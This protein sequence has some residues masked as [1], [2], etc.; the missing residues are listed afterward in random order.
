MRWLAF[1]GYKAQDLHLGSQPRTTCH[2]SLALS[3]SPSGSTTTSGLAS[4]MIRTPL[5]SNAAIFLLSLLRSP[6]HQ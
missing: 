2:L 1:I 5:A 6:L 3:S 4:Q